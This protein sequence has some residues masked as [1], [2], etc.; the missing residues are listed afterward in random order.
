MALGLSWRECC[1]LY[2]CGEQTF[3]SA[4]AALS[5]SLSLLRM[6]ASEGIAEIAEK[7][8]DPGSKLI[9]KGVIARVGIAIGV[10]SS[11]QAL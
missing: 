7:I 8:S 6:L 11:G 5:S 2:E 9:A 1:A 3:F 10:M 4:R